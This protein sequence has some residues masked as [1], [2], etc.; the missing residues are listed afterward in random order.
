MKIIR[1]RSSNAVFTIVDDV[2]QLNFTAAGYQADSIA[3]LLAFINTA[4]HEVVTGI[5]APAIFCP[6]ALTYTTED[7]W[8]IIDPSAVEVTRTRLIEDRI[9]ALDAK[10][11]E[12]RTQYIAPYTSK[13]VTYA[14]KN[15]AAQAVLSGAEPNHPLLIPL[16]GIQVDDARDGA[17][18]E[19]VLEVSEVI[20]RKAAETDAHDGHIDAVVI[21]AKTNM[22]VATSQEIIDYEFSLAMDELSSYV[23]G[24]SPL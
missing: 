1:D 7:G 16:V 20:R 15:A 21:A 19:T 17:V 10:V 8:Q 5:S 14:R 24:L 3:P 4:T 23:A 22:R 2:V 18:C 6:N 12:L 13:Q 9:A 11:N